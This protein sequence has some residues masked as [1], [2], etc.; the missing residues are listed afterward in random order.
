MS[1]KLQRE[2]KQ[3]ASQFSVALTR[4]EQARKTRATE[5]NLSGLGLTELPE[6][7]GQLTQLQRLGL[8]GNQL[9][10]L[11]ESLGQLTQL[12]ELDLSKNQLTALPESLRQLKSL[13]RLFLHGNNALTIPAGV[14]GPTFADVVREIAQPAKPSEIF[15]YY[16]RVLEGRRP[17]NEAKLILSYSHKDENLRNELETHVN[18]HNAPFAKLQALPKAGRAVKQWPDK[19]SAWRNVA[20]GIERVVEEMRKQ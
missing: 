14:L 9:T 2:N 16:F 6:L 20:E 7:L 18:W 19:D 4:I 10:A 3:N 8:A 11:P 12:R 13:E 15:E 17:L 5:L 1:S